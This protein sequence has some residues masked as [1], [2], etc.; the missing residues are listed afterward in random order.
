MGLLDRWRGK[1]I[2]LTDGGFWTMFLGVDSY[3]G[4]P[5]TP[6]RALQLATVWSCVRLLSETIATL[7]L[8]VF[9]KNDEGH[10]QAAIGHPLYKLLHDQPNADFTAVEFWEGVVACL[11]LWGN[12]YAEKSTSAGEI[13]ALTLL[14]PECMTVDRDENGALR[15]TYTGD[16]ERRVYREGSIFHV[17]GFGAGLDT[18]LSPIAFARQTLGTAMA[19]DEAA[20]KMFANGV[21]PTGVL[22]IDQ[23]LKAEQREQLKKAI[24]EPM[25]GSANAGGIFTLEAGMKFQP[26]TMNPEDA[27]MLETRAF[28][29]EEI[30]R[31]FRVPPF[32]IGH[33]EKSTSWG[34]GLE[35]QMIA[36]LTFA[37]RPYL[38]R[39]EQAVKRQLLSPVER[40][41]FFA[42]F[43]LEGLL[44][45]DSQGR[46]ALYNTFAQNGINTRNEIR[47]R[48]NLPPMPGG[49]VLTVQSNLVP[50]DQ[51][52]RFV[53]ERVKALMGHYGGP[54]LED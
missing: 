35:Q 26:I 9:E 43:N 47:A 45:A 54:P 24:V 15:Y 51:L 5:V 17:R 38:A 1:R 6:D 27:Q 32:M 33:S 44:R 11:C 4:K 22:T 53:D 52:G 3:A 8:G 36:F 28:H 29:V 50:L 12:A 48:E 19:A 21:R 49:D 39:I 2:K 37:L 23:V 30:C 14:R 46:A 25:A 40:L 7:P 41:R 18:G 42:E 31:W 13:R 10:K 20:A 34:T 16:G